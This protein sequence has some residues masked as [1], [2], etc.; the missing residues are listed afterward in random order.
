MNVTN[1]R[2][3]LLVAPLAACTLLDVEDD[4]TSANPGEEEASGAGSDETES[5]EADSGEA[6]SGEAESGGATTGVETDGGAEEESSSSG[7]GGGNTNVPEQ[8]VGSWYTG[9]GET[10]LEEL[11]LFTDGTY[12]EERKGEGDVEGCYTRYT[13]QL[14]GEYDATDVLV[15]HPTT[16]HL[17]VDACGTV[18]ES[19]ELQPDGVFDYVL[20][21][22]EWGYTLRLTPEGGAWADSV[23][24]HRL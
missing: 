12:L 11:D 23:L 5:G 3:L 8:L 10:H 1:L 4:A 7:G 24:Y 2:M 21:A 20:G 9:N 14:S 15:L 17:Y 18:E 6:D 16:S 13:L 19:D 22:D